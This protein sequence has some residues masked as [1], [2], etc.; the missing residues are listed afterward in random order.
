MVEYTHTMDTQ[1]SCLGNHE[2]EKWIET[3]TRGLCDE[4][5]ERIA[6]E[7][8][9]HV[10]ETM[11][12]LQAEGITVDNAA[13]EVLRQL[14]SPKAACRAPRRANWTARE[15]A[16]L[17]DLP[18]QCLYRIQGIE[19]RF[20]LLFWSV[21]KV[22]CTVAIMLLHSVFNQLSAVQSVLLWAW[23]SPGFA[24]LGLLPVLPR[25]L[26]RRGLV[27]CAVAVAAVCRMACSLCFLPA[28][29]LLVFAPHA[30]M[31]FGYALCFLLPLLEHWRVWRKLG[32]VKL[33][34][35]RMN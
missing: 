4:A 13:A 32:Y 15:C 28:L 24:A 1:A 18:E 25:A 21:A 20:S 10:E 35:S 12:G 33:P 9:T 5:R 17:L 30:S 11:Q 22:I 16:Y 27:R 23:L 8:R 3:A 31:A 7:I 14:G 19:P 29:F 2:F 6:A 34:A 26:V